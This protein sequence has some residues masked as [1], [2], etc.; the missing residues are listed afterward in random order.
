MPTIAN[1]S[2]SAPVKARPLALVAV[3]GVIGGAVTDGWAPVAG[4]VELPVTDVVH[5]V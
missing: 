1:A 3:L 2:I 5:P 4:G